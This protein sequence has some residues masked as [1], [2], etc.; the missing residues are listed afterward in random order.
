MKKTISILLAAVMVLT[1][2]LALASCG[3]KKPA[4]ETQKLIVGAYQVAPEDF[5]DMDEAAI[6][7]KVTADVMAANTVLPAYKRVN[8][9]YVSTEP[10]EINS[11]RKVIRS[12]VEE[13][14]YNSLK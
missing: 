1:C 5:P 12:K 6:R 9:V 10:F 11:T 8:D 2:A 7:E 4:E 3:G 13:R 14:Y